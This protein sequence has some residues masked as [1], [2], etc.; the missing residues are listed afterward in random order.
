M[1]ALNATKV[2]SQQFKHEDACPLFNPH[3]E[4]PQEVAEVVESFNKSDGSKAVA[5]GCNTCTSHALHNDDD[6][7][8]YVYYVAQN[9]SDGSVFFGFGSE[10]AAH[11]LIGCAVQNGVEYDWNGETTQK[12]LIGSSNDD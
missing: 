7:D 1:E 12:V 3:H 8:S 5:A 9:S 4:I 2:G 6:V 10:A 11:Q